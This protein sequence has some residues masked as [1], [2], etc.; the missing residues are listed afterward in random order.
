MEK[1]NFERQLRNS[2]LLSDQVAVMGD[3]E[4]VW[5]NV[6]MK[7]KSNPAWRYV[8]AIVLMATCSIIFWRDQKDL[9]VKQTLAVPHVTQSSKPK[10]IIQTQQSARLAQIKVKS[11]VMAA[12]TAAVE[13]LQPRDTVA[14]LIVPQPIESAKPETQAQAPTEEFTVQLKRDAPINESKEG[15]VLLKKGKRTSP[16]LADANERP[17]R[18]RISFKKDNL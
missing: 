4:N 10:P 6:R 12:Q 15:P 3:R 7:R 13:P 16:F 8:A 14:K 5:R 1:D 18:I 9:P 2:V 11:N 17:V